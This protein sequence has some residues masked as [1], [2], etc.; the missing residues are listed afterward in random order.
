MLSQI[1]AKLF[2]LKF[3]LGTTE[4]INTVETLQLF[5]ANIESNEFSEIIKEDAILNF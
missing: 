3:L 4:L 5:N 1:L 2:Q